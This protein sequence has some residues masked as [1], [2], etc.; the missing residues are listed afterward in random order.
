MVVVAAFSTSQMLFL[1]AL[2]VGMALAIVLDITIVRALLVPATMRLMGR[3]NWYAPGP[4]AR[5][6]KRSSIGSSEE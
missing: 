1:K 3:W 6:A 4:L 5:L 2:G